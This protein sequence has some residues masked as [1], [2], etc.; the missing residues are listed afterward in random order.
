MSGWSVTVRVELSE[1]R[2]IVNS[3]PLATSPSVT[4]FCRSVKIGFCRLPIAVISSPLRMPARQAA[5]PGRTLDT[6]QVSSFTPRPK[7]QEAIRKAKIVFMMT[8]AEMIA[9]RLGTLWAG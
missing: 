2:W 5:P 1:G 9:I 7:A 3:T 6:A 8:P 4:P